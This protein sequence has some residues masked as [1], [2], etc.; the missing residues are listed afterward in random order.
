MHLANGSQLSPGNTSS[1]S[2]SGNHVNHITPF[3]R[4]GRSAKSS[5][6]TRRVHSFSGRSFTIRELCTCTDFSKP[7]EGQM[8]FLPAYSGENFSTALADPKCVK[9]NLVR[10]YRIT[11]VSM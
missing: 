3:R 9:C 7:L 4:F 1:Q 5:E 10:P 8:S 6:D 11:S 2:R